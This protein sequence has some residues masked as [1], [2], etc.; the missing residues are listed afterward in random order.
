MSRRKSKMLESNNAVKQPLDEIFKNGFSVDFDSARFTIYRTTRGVFR[1]D[2]RASN[3]LIGYGERED[4]ESLLER[5]LAASGKKYS[6]MVVEVIDMTKDKRIESVPSVSG[7]SFFY[8]KKP[9]V[10]KEIERIKK[11][12]SRIE[13]NTNGIVDTTRRV[14]IPVLILPDS[15]MDQTTATALYSLVTDERNMN[16][17]IYPMVLISRTA[18]MPIALLESFEVFAAIGEENSSVL[19]EVHPKPLRAGT[20][21]RDWIGIGYSKRMEMNVV[22]HPTDTKKGNEYD[23]QI[24]EL[25]KKRKKAYMDYLNSLDTEMLEE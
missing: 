23:R 10:I 11:I 3:A 7:I 21:K 1:W 24:K 17:E 14:Y 18:R 9:D 2:R 13:K 19:E 20:P 4:L 8:K 25:K 5:L 22:L 15:D 12:A 16:L 6:D